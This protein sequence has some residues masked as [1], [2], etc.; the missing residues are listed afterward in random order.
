M[1]QAF[2]KRLGLARL[3]CGAAALIA[4]GLPALGQT[5]PS[6]VSIILNSTNV[7]DNLFLISPMDGA[8]WDYSGVSQV[9][10]TNGSVCRTTASAGTVTNALF[11]VGDFT[12]NY[13]LLL[14]QYVPLLQLGQQRVPGNEVATF[15][16]AAFDAKT[17][18]AIT[19]YPDPNMDPG[20]LALMLTTNINAVLQGPSIYDAARFANVTLSQATTDLL[21]ANPPTTDTLL[22]N[23][24][25]LDDASWAT[26]PDPSAYTAG[27]YLYFQAATNFLYQATNAL[28]DNMSSIYVAVEY[29]DV[30]NDLWQLQYD[31]LPDPANPNPDVDRFT[32]SQTFGDVA[33]NNSG[34][35]LT[36]VFHLPFAYF[37]KR[38]PGGADFRIW[39]EGDGPE[40]IRKVSISTTNPINYH[41]YYTDTP[42][43]IDGKLDDAAWANAMPFVVN[44]PNQ[45]VWHDSSAESPVG[46]WTT[47]V[48]IENSTNL[49]Y[50]NTD[51][52][53]SNF[54]EDVFT[55]NTVPNYTNMWSAVSKAAWDSNYFYVAVD[56][57]DAVPRDNQDQLDGSLTNADGTTWT[58]ANGN[59]HFANLSVGD[60]LEWFFSYD[61]S[62][63]SR[64]TWNYTNDFQT[65][66]SFGPHPNMG[67]YQQGV[68]S[69]IDYADHP[70]YAP[71]NNIAIVDHPDGKGYTVEARFPWGVL[72]GTDGSTFWHTNT[73][74][75][76]GQ[77]VGFN[78]GF[79]NGNDWPPT[80][81]GYWT[82]SAQPGDWANPSAWVSLQMEAAPATAPPRLWV[83]TS[84]HGTL[85]INWPDPVAA[86]LV[87]LQA[88]AVSGPWTPATNAVTQ[89]QGLKSYIE[90]DAS[91]GTMFYR[92][93]PASV[94]QQITIGETNVLPNNDGGNGGLALAQSATLSETATIQSLSF[95]V[96]T[97][98]GTLQLG[99]YSD[100]GGQPGTLMAS[101]ATFTPVVG[102]NTQDVTTPVSLP[103]GTYWLAY[104]PSDNGLGFQNDNTGTAFWQGNYTTL[105]SPY[106]S[107][108]SGSGSYHWSLYATLSK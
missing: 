89:L 97:A 62:D 72:V 33:K 31:A 75:V 90:V 91:T 60:A 20:L 96:R 86:G 65:L 37:G 3:A 94:A 38:Q 15:L 18:A 44:K 26:L 45:L 99:I 19:N 54:F 56:I 35:W 87:L 22:L 23:R 29:L 104:L 41:I 83:S 53:L 55:T 95:Y 4:L 67:V 103:A 79:D 88:P 6:Y 59:T 85:L 48:V 105:P 92:L 108:P 98:A 30:G 28:G 32:I 24:L 39:D 11:A 46:Y 61:R 7:P 78:L 25:L 27:G 43:K 2:V 84:S 42:V 100:N 8:Q 64:S 36:K 58:D 47:N 9:V 14:E 57:W 69:P 77:M 13:D 102:W 10:T 1:K 21:N 82:F 63:P 93:G 49:Y 66:I 40:Y 68:L 73:A 12:N 52:S 74:P 17:Q 16:V 107:N 70:D 81:Q 80:Q 71:S 101:T 106:P 5:P 51:G 34:Q 50:T 76:M